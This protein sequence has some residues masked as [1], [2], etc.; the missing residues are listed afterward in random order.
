MFTE[1][2]TQML[3]AVQKKDKKALQAMLTDG[4]G[5][6]MPDANRIE[7]EDWLDSIM[8]QGFTLA[9]FGVAQV[10]LTDLGNAAVVKYVRIQEASFNGTSDNG[11]F[12]VVDL[13]NKDGNT[14]KLSNRHV[15]KVSS[16]IPPIK[17]TGKE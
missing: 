13:W 7:G 9:R 17:P 12:L 11:E 4:F 16:Q 8:A 14:W 6:E 10:S 15:C 2:E 5:I 1:L 3:R